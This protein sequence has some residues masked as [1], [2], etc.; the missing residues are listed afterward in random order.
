MHEV[1]IVTRVHEGIVHKVPGTAAS[2]D[3]EDEVYRTTVW[4]SSSL[5]SLL[6]GEWFPGIDEPLLAGR[7]AHLGTD[8]QFQVRYG[9][10]GAHRYRVPVPRK[11]HD[12][13]FHVTAAE[14]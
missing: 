14:D 9:G 1:L 10:K 5:D 11:R 7:D 6:V 2:S 12:M 13:N 4:D 3:R 8:G